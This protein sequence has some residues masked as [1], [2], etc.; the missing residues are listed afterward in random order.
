MNKIT[1]NKFP[2]LVWQL[3]VFLSIAE[4]HALFPVRCRRLGHRAARHHRVKLAIKV[5]IWSGI[6]VKLSPNDLVWQKPLKVL[7]KW[8]AMVRFTAQ[9]S[10]WVPVHL[11][12]VTEVG[13]LLRLK[14]RLVHGGREGGGKGNQEQ[15]KE[16]KMKGFEFV[17]RIYC[18]YFF[19]VKRGINTTT[20]ILTSIIDTFE[21]VVIKKCS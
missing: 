7:G 11:D 16:K 3:C 10:L 6:E 2:G 15:N 19:M 4:T 13:S 8:L 17:K 5:L 1:R 9:G 14:R 18:C 21:M 12:W 20:N